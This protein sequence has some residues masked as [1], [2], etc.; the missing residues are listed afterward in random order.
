MIL[1]LF[2]N[3]FASL[4]SVHNGWVALTGLF[5]SFSSRGKYM[6]G[7]IILLALS[8]IADIV[9][10]ALE[11]NVTGRL[12]VGQLVSICVLLFKCVILYI[13]FHCYLDLGGTWSLSNGANYGDISDPIQQQHASVPTMSGNYQSPD[14]V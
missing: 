4:V 14:Q 12:L 3:F 13:A 1:T 8:M 10:L 5:A 6:F 2:G 7:F 9:I 11:G